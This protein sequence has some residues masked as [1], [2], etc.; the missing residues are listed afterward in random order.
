MVQWL[1]PHLAMQRVQVKSLARELRSHMPWGQKTK[2]E[3]RC[4]IVTFNKDFKIDP[5]Q[6]Q[7]S[8][9]KKKRVGIR[10]EPQEDGSLTP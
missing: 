5:H 9:K 10:A 6:K 7:K 3:S 2:T 4:N 1:R 8:L